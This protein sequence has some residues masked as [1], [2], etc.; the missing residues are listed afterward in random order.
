MTERPIL[1]SA[2]MIQAIL[3]GRKSQTRRIIKP[4]RGHNHP[5]GLL[6]FIQERMTYWFSDSL[7]H[8]NP[9][10][11][12]EKKCPYGV[13]GD[14]LWVRETWGLGGS[15][16]VDPCLNYRADGAQIPLHKRLTKIDGTGFDAIH[17]ECPGGFTDAA[18]LL[19]IATRDKWHPSIHMPR[20]AS[21]IT[22][23]ITGVRVER[24][25]EITEADAVAEGIQNIGGRFTFNGGLHESRTAIDSF[26]ALW[27]SINGE[28]SFDANPFVFVLEFRRA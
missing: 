20:W 22:L 9:F 23:E 8:A 16:L 2:P 21:R 14:R 19:A 13:P 10:P 5:S 1:F 18:H 12:F 24:L 6:G 27:K 26:Y 3:A 4:P 15:L 17:W 7:P 28:E 25:Q 11:S